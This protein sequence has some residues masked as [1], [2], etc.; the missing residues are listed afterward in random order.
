MTSLAETHPQ[1]ERRSA[2]N[3]QAL[4]K[5]NSAGMHE[6]IDFEISIVSEF[7]LDEI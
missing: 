7:D 1:I 3:V 2:D 6:G 5:R 4:R